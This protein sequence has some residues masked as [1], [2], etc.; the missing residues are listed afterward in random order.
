[1]TGRYIV[2]PHPQGSDGW[3][4][5]R[6]G[7]VTGSVS[8][9][10]FATVKSGEAA[11]RANLRM[12]LVLE[13]ITQIPTPATFKETEAIAWGKEQEPFSRMAYELE[14]DLTIEELGFIYLRDCE[15]GCSVDGL[16]RDAGRLG[17]WESKSPNSKTHYA[18][19]RGGVIPSEYM[20][21]V[22]HNFW[23]TGADF[24]DF[25]SYD[26]RMPEKLRTF[27]KRIERAEVADRI[28]AHE[29]GVLQFL[30]EVDAE[31]KQMRLMAA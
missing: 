8:E 21:Q 4:M 16:V 22:L 29:R 28:A 9:A 10:V 17:F 18:Y 15:A 26:P 30:A 6:L 3:R 19:L 25:Q 13:R 27:I 14:R 12:A 7:K 31:E 23:I 24:C 1:M 2:C 5:D 20:P 11:T